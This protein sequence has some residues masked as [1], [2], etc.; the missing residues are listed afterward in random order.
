MS[1]PPPPPGSGGASGNTSGNVF[2]SFAAVQGPFGVQHIYHPPPPPPRR[3]WAVV[4]GVVSV[5]GAAA[6]GA[7]LVLH[8]ADEPGA[9][10][11][12]PAGPAAAG[13]AAAPAPGT[14]A[15]DAPPGGPDTAPDTPEPPGEGGAGKDAERWAG[16]LLI[17]V[18]GHVLDERPP[19]RQPFFGD[20]RLGEDDPPVLYGSELAAPGSTNLA[21]WQRPAAPTRE[22]CAEL[23]SAQGVDRV[24]V[25]RGSVVCVRTQG[26]RTAVL[27]VVS[28]GG[29]A[30][31]GVRAET[32]VWS[33]TDRRGPVS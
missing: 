6:A 32:R 18:N 14:S 16:T 30:R 29:D 19:V 8:F 3:A 10:A 7:L 20:V 22:E 33:A 21:L 17:D 24:E 13:T 4:A 23:V 1:L 28:A 25:G 2:D 11:R 9:G 26:G 27:T 5:V 31:G 15:P 12:P